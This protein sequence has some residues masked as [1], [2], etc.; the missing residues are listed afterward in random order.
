M[1]KNQ[2]IR[3]NLPFLFLIIPQMYLYKV[4]TLSCELVKKRKQKFDMIT[5]LC[6]FVPEIIQYI[7]I[8]I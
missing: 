8:K 5:K 3:Y 6:K 1:A 7:T 2:M 4:E